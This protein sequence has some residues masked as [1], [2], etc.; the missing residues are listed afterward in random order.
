MWALQTYGRPFAGEGVY[1]QRHS[2]EDMM[3]TLSLLDLRSDPFGSLLVLHIQPPLLDS[4]RAILARLGP[5]VAPRELVLR[6][7]KALYV[8]WALVYAATAALV[9]AWLRRISGRPALA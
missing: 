5:D 4:L 7:D 8:L 9:F 3:Q 2:S 1:F 6:V